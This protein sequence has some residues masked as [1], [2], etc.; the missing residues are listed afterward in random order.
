MGISFST[1][2]VKASH[3]SLM[4]KLDQIKGLDMLD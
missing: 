1:A 2:N 4:P 3:L